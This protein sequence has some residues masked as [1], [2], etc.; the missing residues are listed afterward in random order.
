MVAGYLQLDRSSSRGCRPLVAGSVTELVSIG[1]CEVIQDR[2]ASRSC[3]G[4]L[5]QV[6]SIV[7]RKWILDKVGGESNLP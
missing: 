1:C 2:G 6:N 5:A 7:Y 4:V 3:Q